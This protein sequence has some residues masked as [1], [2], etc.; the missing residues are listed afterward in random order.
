MGWQTEN[1]KTGIERWQSVP[2]ALYFTAWLFLLLFYQHPVYL[3]VLGV[4]LLLLAASQGVGKKARQSL[5]WTMPMVILFLL[6]N[7][8]VSGQGRQTLFVVHVFQSA[9]P[10]YREALIYGTAMGLKLADLVLLFVLVNRFFGPDRLIEV[11]GSR[12]YKPV[13]VLALALRMIPC[14]L[15]DIE[16][17]RDTF[18]LRGT[19]PNRKKLADMRQYFP[20]IRAVLVAG[21][22]SA[23]AWAEALQVRGYGCGPRSHY[24]REVWGAADYAAIIAAFMVTGTAVASCLLGLGHYGYYQGTVALTC[25]G[26]VLL[27]GTEAL[28]LLFPG[29]LL[30]EGFKGW[31]FFKSRT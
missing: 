7:T 8:L 14:L 17:I 31:R 19:M 18:R 10:V 28:A 30:S 25:S 22:D 15:K 6:I 3:A 9:R 20:F 16:Q 1:L 24:F 4:V 11:T 21:L 23:A 27:V 29:L 12:L 13:L 26:E 2:M 5:V